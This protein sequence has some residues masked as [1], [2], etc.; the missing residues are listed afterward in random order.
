MPVL[1]KSSPCAPP[2]PQ[3]P[4]TAAPTE[5]LPL[6]AALAAALTAALAAALAVA[7]AT[8]RTFGLASR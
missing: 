4:A 5:S 1:A 6:M 8:Q 2:R 7:S 3:P